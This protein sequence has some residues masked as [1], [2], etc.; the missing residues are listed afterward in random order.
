MIR[1]DGGTLTYTY[2]ATGPVASVKD[3]RGFTTS[4]V[5]NGLGLLRQETS[6]DRGVT[7]Y[8]Y[9][10]AGRLET[11]TPAF[12]PVVTYAFD[13]V[14]R[15][16]SRT[17]GGVSE[18]WAY[19][20]PTAYG[21]GRL[22]RITD[23]TGQTTFA[24]TAAGELQQQV[25]TILGSTYT[26]TWNY[27]AA[28][29]LLGLTYPAGGPSLTYSYD[30]YGRVSRITSGASTLVDNI[31]YQPATNRRYAWRFGNNLPRL[32]TLDADG[33]VAQLAGSSAHNVSLGY[34]NNNTVSGLTDA[35]Q[36][37]LNA[38][39]GYDAIEQ[40]TSV[41]RSADNQSF[42]VDKMANRLSHTRQGV[43]ATYTYDPS[44]NR[45]SSWVGGGASRAFGYYANG[46]VSTETRTDGQ[47]NYTYDA[48]NR[49]SLVTHN[50]A[51]LGD[52]R[53][54][55]F[56]Q[57]AAKIAGGNTKR[58][59]YGPD[60]QM[61][62]EYGSTQTSFH[63]W[64][65]DEPVMLVRGGQ[66][67]ASHNDH[68]GRPEVLTN[69][70]GAV[71]WRA[72]NAAFDRVV[73]VDTIGGLNIGLP[74]Q[75][76]DTETALWQNW[77]R[78]YDAGLGRYTQSDPIGLEGGINTYAYAAGNPLSNVDPNGLA[79]FDF[80]KFA[81]QIEENRSSTAAN[82]AALG[83]AFAVGTMPKTPGE[84]RGLGVP[85]SE[86]NPYTS[87]MSRWAG[88]TDMRGLRDFGRTALGQG[89]SAAAT[90]ALVFD[91]FYN[92][93]VIGKAAWDATSSEQ[94]CGCGK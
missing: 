82:L 83:G 20:D 74:G 54:N 22:T 87:Q 68:L 90:A 86:L 29:R 40:L 79:C 76:A 45:L 19:D 77:H 65:G 25:N 58:F 7:Q 39:F 2:D 16:T 92:W 46:N 62:A 63:L 91:G 49:L 69:G 34:Y 50:G 61:L 43:G 80:N 12:G 13:A 55:A 52:Y 35:V 60:G 9:D 44:S 85:R 37:G 5:Y 14:D 88:R 15:L 11:M 32:V 66:F 56:G 81:N 24:Y 31:L 8:T 4:Y 18:T 47:R 10:T 6:P 17:A 59:I 75:Y 1:P 72:Q 41:T 30:S 78:Y 38:S 42:G 93:G 73:T 64:L 51:T 53:N 28:G 3:P 71:V 84:L 67:Y 21:K 48:F 27:D 26:T 33:R 57:R 94:N 23:A 89:V 36:P 70:A